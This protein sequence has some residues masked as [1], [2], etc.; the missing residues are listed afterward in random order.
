MA[1]NK[2]LLKGAIEAV[3]LQALADDGEAYGYELIQR[4]AKQS[5]DVFTFQEGTLY[6]LLYRIE[7]RGYVTSTRKVATSGKER[8]YY[9]ITPAGKTFL[10]G[11]RDEFNTLFNAL[12]TSLHFANV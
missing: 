11:R 5:N 7:D 1:L 9:A 12:K 2:E 3:V 6:P 10:N 8:R 4:I